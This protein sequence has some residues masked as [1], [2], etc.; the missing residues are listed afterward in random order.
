MPKSNDFAR[1]IDQLR[2]SRNL[3][4]EAFVKNILSLRQY[5]RYIKGENSLKD[6]TVN[7]LLERLEI[8]PIHAYETFRK[9]QDKDYHDLTKVYEFIHLGKFKLAQ[10][11]FS[12]LE[13]SPLLSTNNI[14]LLEYIEIRLDLHFER[15]T[16]QQAHLEIIE[17]LDYPDVLSKESLSYIE[18]SCILFISDEMI[19]EDDYRLAD[20]G[21]DLLI[22]DNQNQFSEF[23]DQLLPLQLTVVKGL[24][25][26]GK[27]EESIELSQKAICE[28][29][30]HHPL[31]MLLSI[32]YIKALSERELY[33]DDR[34]VETLLQIF[35]ICRIMRNSSL[36]KQ[37]KKLISNVFD[38]K[39]SDLIIYRKIK[40]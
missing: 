21:Y 35:S 1:F 5:Y 29:E 24:G 27:F 36:V 12:S 11:I 33:K 34:Y 15:I 22:K 6:E 9:K 10:E 13:L 37:T 8:S 4:R 2:D 7:L 28:F 30:V 3:S 16:Q 25:R 19:K 18:I 31:N 20:Y 39:E 32:N 23:K 40:K 38:I 17:L 26:I 14:K